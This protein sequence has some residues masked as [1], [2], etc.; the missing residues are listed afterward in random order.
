MRVIVIVASVYTEI[1]IMY[2]I[3]YKLTLYYLL[4]KIP[5]VAWGKGIHP[6]SPR[7]IFKL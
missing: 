2:E 1:T 6:F 3:R 5:S 4:A 7:Q